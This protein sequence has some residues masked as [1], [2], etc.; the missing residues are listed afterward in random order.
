MD[1]DEDLEPW[2]WDPQEKGLWS[3]NGPST[4][5]K[6]KEEIEETRIKIDK[7]IDAILRKREEADNPTE[8]EIYEAMLESKGG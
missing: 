1:K 5:K 6:T 4:R 7:I 8:K 2:D 3:F